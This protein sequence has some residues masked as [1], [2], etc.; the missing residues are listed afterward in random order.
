MFAG[1]S[2]RM[3][4]S[5]IDTVSTS[6]APGANGGSS[7]SVTVTVIV[8]SAVNARSPAPLVTV[9]TTTYWLLFASFAGVVL[10]A[11][12]GSS[13]FGAISNSNPLLSSIANN[14]LSAP[15]VIP[16]L[17][18]VSPS[19]SVACRVTANVTFSATLGDAV[20]VNLGTTLSLVAPSPDSDQSPVPSSLFASTCTSYPVPVFRF[21]ITVASV[22]VVV[23]STTVQDPERGVFNSRYR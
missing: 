3:R 16:K 22:A 14:S 11:S 13:K 20:L 7:A 18:M 19:S 15:P 21:P 2:H 4:N 8:C 17:T 1:A 6:G 5:V 23:P 9:T 10:A 12:F